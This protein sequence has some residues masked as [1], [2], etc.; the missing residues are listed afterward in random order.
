M[1]CAEYEPQAR[2]ACRVLTDATN[3]EVEGIWISST[4]QLPEKIPVYAN[5]VLA[6][7]SVLSEFDGFPN[8]ERFDMVSRSYAAK[9]VDIIGSKLFDPQASTDTGDFFLCRVF[10][11][12]MTLS[13][14]AAGAFRSDLSDF[15]KEFLIPL[16][17]AA[18]PSLSA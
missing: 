3:Q 1:G 2:R 5:L 11:E 18:A 6:T 7:Q 14:T 8:W 12:S 17:A 9:R 10:W 13:I 16:A 15:A 4:P